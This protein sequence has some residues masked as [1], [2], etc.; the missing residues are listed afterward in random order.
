MKSLSPLCPLFVSRQCSSIALRC[1]AATSAAFVS[2]ALL[3]PL[4]AKAQTPAPTTQQTM[5][6]TA[7]PPS[8]PLDVESDISALR[9][10]DVRKANGQTVRI[11]RYESGADLLRNLKQLVDEELLIERNLFEIDTVLFFYQHANATNLTLDATNRVISAYKKPLQIARNIGVEGGALSWNKQSLKTLGR[12]SF[13]FSVEKQ[14]LSIDDWNKVFKNTTPVYTL[15]Y[16]TELPPVTRRDIAPHAQFIV[17]A[18]HPLGN[19]YVDAQFDTVNT[20]VKIRLNIGYNGYL[21]TLRIE[22]T[23]K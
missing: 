15:N 22:Q 4:V 17:T 7:P 14:T 8:L 3:N 18:T 6:Q 10:V 11:H 1:I 16:S 5:P 13:S 9:Y 23:E 21:K 12:A 20:A 2:A 19:H